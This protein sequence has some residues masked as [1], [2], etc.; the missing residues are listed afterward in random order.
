MGPSTVICILGSV[1]T[2][3]RDATRPRSVTLTSSCV[4]THVTRTPIVHS[5]MTYVFKTSAIRSLAIAATL[6]SHV[7]I[8]TSDCTD[9]ITLGTTSVSALIYATHQLVSVISIPRLSVQRVRSVIRMHCPLTRPVFL[10]TQWTC[11][12]KPLCH[13]GG[14]WST[15]WVAPLVPFLFVDVV[16][17]FYWPCDDEKRDAP[18]DK[19]TDRERRI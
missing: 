11:R 8:S 9:R 4:S 16:F 5:Q 14:P 7:T 13:H 1:N 3:T 19:N 17:G 18:F 6:T 2:R 10:A 15:Y 12:R